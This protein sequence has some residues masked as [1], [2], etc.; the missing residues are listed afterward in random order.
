LTP[1]AGELEIAKENHVDEK[2]ETLKDGTQVTIRDLRLDDLDPLL[3]FYRGLPPED[4]KYLRVDVTD[5]EIV[6]QRIKRLETGE[7]ARIVALRGA[8]IVADGLLEM[9]GD[10]WSKHQGEIRVFVAQPFRQK[11]LG[12][13]LIRELYFVAVKKNLESIVARMMRPQVEAEHIFRRLGFRELILPD[14]AKDLE[15]A[16]QDLIIMTCSVKDLW[17]ELDHLMT[18]DWQRCR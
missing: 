12:T 6:S 16:T 7:V 9:S 11:G 1:Q 8:E 10:T 3:A 17:K 2:T 14:F 5:R 4:R 18:S 13:T 15:G